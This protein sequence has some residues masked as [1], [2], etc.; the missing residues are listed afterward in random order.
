[1][2]F[3]LS[4][5]LIFFQCLLMVHLSFQIEKR[6]MKMS[7]HED[8][9]LFGPNSSSSANGSQTISPQAVDNSV[10]SVVHNLILTCRNLGSLSCYQLFSAFKYIVCACICLVVDNLAFALLLFVGLF[11]MYDL[12]LSYSVLAIVVC[13]IKTWMLIMAIYLR[14]KATHLTTNDF[15][16]FIDTSKF[17][18]GISQ[19]SA[20]GNTVV[21]D[22][23]RVSVSSSA[24]EGTT[25]EGLVKL[26]HHSGQPSGQSSPGN[27]SQT[28]LLA[29]DQEDAQS[30]EEDASKTN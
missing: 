10:K 16:K 5:Q 30:E 26:H 13:P 2:K 7:F 14:Y 27:S 22:T 15:N 4:V 21:T 20:P 18:P 29:Y 19:A 25:M 1:M 8:T 17:R 28:R 12:Y 23:L 24:T 6:F 3:L 9:R 11:Q